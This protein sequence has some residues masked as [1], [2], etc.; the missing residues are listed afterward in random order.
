MSMGPATVTEC[1]FVTRYRL[2]MIDP[3]H[4]V[5]RGITLQVQ[6]GEW[7]SPVMVFSLD[8]A[9]ELIQGIMRLLNKQRQ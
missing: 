9:S 1:G 7:Q 6:V 2:G 8:S 3:E 4:E 5:D